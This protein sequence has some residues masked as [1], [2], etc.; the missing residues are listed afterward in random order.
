MNVEELSRRTGSG[1]KGVEVQSTLPAAISKSRSP[2]S[3][4]SFSAAISPKAFT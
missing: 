2:V 3:V 1:A 4:N